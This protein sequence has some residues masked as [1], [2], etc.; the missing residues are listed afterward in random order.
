MF[1]ILPLRKLQPD[2]PSSDRQMYPVPLRRV[3]SVPGDRAF[4]RPKAPVIQTTQ[5]IQAG[6]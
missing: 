4:K 5:D 6:G 2:I 1:P 3:P